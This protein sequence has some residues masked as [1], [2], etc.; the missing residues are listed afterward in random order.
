MNKITKIVAS[1]IL[2]FAVS[3]SAFA[4]ELTVTGTAKA[5]YSTY[6]G[7]ANGDNSIGVANELGFSAAG[8]LD[9][10]W[11]WNYAIALDPDGTTAGGGSA[12]NDDS[13]LTLTT[14]YGTFAACGS[15]CGLGAQLA[16]SANAYAVI[17][18]T[19]FAE[20]KQEPVNISSY[21]NVQYHTPAGL[22]PFGTVLKAAYA[23][24]GNTVNGSANTANTTKSATIGNT[25]QYSISTSPIDG[26]AV[27]ASYTDQEG[28]DVAGQTDDQ[29]EEG[30]AI[31]ATYAIGSF[32]LGVGKAWRAPVLADVTTST[33]G[34]TT[35][36]FYENTN[37]SVGFNVNDNLSVSFS[38]ETSEVNYLTSTTVAY[39]QETDSI[40]AA[41]T[42]G[43]MT[44][45]VS[46]STYDNVDYKNK[47]DVTETLL[48]VTMAF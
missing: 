20:G 14:P 3:M 44:L 31:A 39:D 38:R 30:G 45:A 36:E 23:P 29:S 7:N 25:T 41:Y 32:K 34:A 16:W 4:G 43:G 21:Q 8:E 22:L 28:G 6:S 24:S 46:R 10:G 13:K 47:N 5:T 17:T 9:N 12:I 42:M 18:D 48:A 11:T 15:D 2:S 26:L 19:A 37:Y 33:N 27:S 35:A 40:Q 1:L